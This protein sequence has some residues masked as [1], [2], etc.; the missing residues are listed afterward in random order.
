M[1]HSTKK[2]K[3]YSLLYVEDEADSREL[4]KSMIEMKFPQLELTTA[5]DGQNGLE[6][7]TKQYKDIL[8]TDIS[9]P[10][11]NGLQMARSIKLMNPEVMIIVLTARADTQFF[12]E[13]IDIGINQFVLKPIDNKILNDAIDKCINSISLKDKI[14]EQNDFIISLN[15]SLTAK[16]SELENLNQE[17]EAFNYTVSHELKSPLAIISGYCQLLTEMYESSL[18]STCLDFI[19]EIL[20]GVNKISELINT[21]LNFSK[22]LN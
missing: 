18:D 14:K 4:L 2:S 5:I 12:I 16:T 6:L 8:V 9:M 1:P 22:I 10:N 7:Y 17:L 3:T 20:Y 15:K 19:N 13:S 11:M 21:L